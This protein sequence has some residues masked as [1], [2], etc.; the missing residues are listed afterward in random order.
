MITVPHHLRRF[1]GVGK[2]TN[3]EFVCELLASKVLIRTRES[4]GT[5]LAE[6]LREAALAVRVKEVSGMTELSLS[7]RRAS[8][9]GAG[10]SACLALGQWVVCDRFTDALPIRL[11]SRTRHRTH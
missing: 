8:A 10:D 2:T 7:L 9:F 4:G 1:R 3:I 11:R 6:A 5:P